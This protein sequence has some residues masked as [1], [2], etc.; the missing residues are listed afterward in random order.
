MVGTAGREA[1]FFDETCQSRTASLRIFAG[2]PL[3]VHRQS[4]L[5][6]LAPDCW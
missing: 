5:I 3:P 1:G 2:Y 4:L 6:E